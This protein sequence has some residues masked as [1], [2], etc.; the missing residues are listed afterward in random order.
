MSAFADRA[1]MGRVAANVAADF[2]DTDAS[3]S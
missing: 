2:R 1:V 3:R